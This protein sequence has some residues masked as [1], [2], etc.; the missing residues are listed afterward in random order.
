MGLGDQLVGSPVWQLRVQSL[1]DIVGPV[2]DASG[3]QRDFCDPIA[4]AW[5]VAHQAPLS[6]GISQA[7]LLEWVV[8]SFSRGSS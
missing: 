7:R 5:T 2:Q 6:I 4:T 1:E 8:I 3:V